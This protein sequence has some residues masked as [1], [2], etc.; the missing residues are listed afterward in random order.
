MKG[1]TGRIIALAL[2]LIIT[3]GLGYVAINGV[4]DNKIGS[5]RDISQGLDLAGGLSITYQVVG[6]GYN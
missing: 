6:E 5:Y 3:A 4:G 2:I 1:R